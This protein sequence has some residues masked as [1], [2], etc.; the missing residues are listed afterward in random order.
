MR[1]LIFLLLAC[2][3]LAS[4]AE[5]QGGG[6]RRV[7]LVIGNAAYKEAPLKNPANDARDIAAALRRLGFE[8]VEKTN[9]TQKEMNRAIVQFGEKL[10]A[11]TIALFYYAGHGMQVKGKNYLIPVD[12]QIQSEASVRS[13][14][15]DVDGVLDQLT[16]L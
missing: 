13:E 1:I 2:L 11:Q 7:A 10:N 14:A 8:V 6:E 4:S 16:K 12:A 5:A 3:S 15:V 9:V